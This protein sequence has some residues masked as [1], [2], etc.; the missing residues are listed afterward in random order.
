MIKRQSELK[1]AYDQHVVVNRK[2]KLTQ[3]LSNGRVPGG[4][5]KGAVDVTLAPSRVVK[6]ITSVLNVEA[7]R[8]DN[9]VGAGN[10]CRH[11]AF[12]M[13]VRGDLFNSIVLS[14]PGMPRDYAHPGAGLA[15]MAHD[16]TANKAG[17]AKP[18]LRSSFPDPSN[19]PLRRC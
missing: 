11:G 1:S 19:D 9:T 6:R 14:Q 2:N 7:D 3:E 16:T 17:P 15:Q 8:V 18:Q 4:R 5:A 12:V 10:G 13:C